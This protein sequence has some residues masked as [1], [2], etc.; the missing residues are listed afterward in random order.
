MFHPKRILVL[1]MYCTCGGSSASGIAEGNFRHDLPADHHVETAA[2]LQTVESHLL[3][4]LELFATGDKAALKGKRDF[5][6]GA[7]HD[8]GGGRSSLQ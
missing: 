6:V 3:R 8:E 4:V 5:V 1:S 2:L 7:T